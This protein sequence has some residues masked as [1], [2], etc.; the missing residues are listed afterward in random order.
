MLDILRK[1]YYGFSLVASGFTI[2]VGIQTLLHTSQQKRRS[3]C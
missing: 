2:L 3:V 1:L